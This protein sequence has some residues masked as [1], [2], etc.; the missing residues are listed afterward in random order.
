MVAEPALG[1]FNYEHESTDQQTFGNVKFPIAWHSH[2]GWDDNFG[3]ENVTAGHNAFG[4]NFAEGRAEQL[5]RRG[6][7]AGRGARSAPAAP[8]AVTVDKLAERRVSARRRAGE[9]HRGGVPDLRRGV[10]GADQRGAQP[11]GDRADREADAG[12]A[13][14]LS[15]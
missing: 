14:P 10:R 8:P 15:W 9:Q 2:Q 6:D 5:R 3:F 4:G 7:G 1:D 11:G 12:Q 13:D